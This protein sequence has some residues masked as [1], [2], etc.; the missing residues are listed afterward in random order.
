MNEIKESEAKILMYLSVVPSTKKNLINICQKLDMNYGYGIVVLREMNGK[1]WVFKHKRGRFMA[2]DL[3]PKAPLDLAKKW[4][5]DNA[6]QMPLPEE[7]TE[8]VEE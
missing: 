5:L 4:Y 3:T 7:Q 2:Y 1:G 6:R 8:L